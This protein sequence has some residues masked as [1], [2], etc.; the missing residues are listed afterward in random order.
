MTRLRYVVSISFLLLAIP[1]SLTAQTTIP[2]QTL[3]GTV[4][5][6]SSMNPILV[7]GDITIDDNATLN[8]GPG[9]DVRFQ[10]YSDDTHWG[11]DITRSEIIVY[12]TLNVNGTAPGL[13]VLTSTGTKPEGW[14][15]IIF[16]GDS[17]S[18]TIQYANIDHSVFGINFTALDTMLATSATD[19]LIHD[20]GMGMYFDN[21]SSPAVADCTVINAEIA[22]GCWGWDTAPA[23]VNC[24]TSGLTGRA[25]AVY[26]TEGTQPVFTGC[27]FS[28][29]SVDL[30]WSAD[31]VLIDT[32]I[33]DAVNGIIGR[34]FREFAGFKFP[35]DCSLTVN[36][37]N[38]IGT[39]NKGNGIAWDDNLNIL[40]V[41]YSRIGGFLRNVYP[42]WG[43]IDPKAGI[44]HVVGPR[45]VTPCYGTCTGGDDVF[46][47]DS[48]VNFYSI[49]ARIGMTVYN[50]TDGSS[51]T[52]VDVI[53]IPSSPITYNTLQTSGMSSGTNDAGDIYHFLPLASY[54]NIDMGDLGT[55]NPYRYWPP[56]HVPSVGQNE[57]YGAQAPAVPPVVNFELEAGS[58]DPP[59]L[60]QL[61]VWAEGCWWVTDNDAVIDR[62]ILDYEEN[63]NVGKVHYIPHRTPDEKR[64]YSVSGAIEDSLGDPVEGVRVSVDISAQFPGHTVLAATTDAS[65][66]YTIYGLLPSATSYTVVP[67]KLG[68]T[69]TP[70]SR[71]VIIDAANPSD[72]TGQ[73]FVAVLPAPVITSASRA[74]GADGGDYG[75][76][77]RTNWGIEGQTTEIVVTGI[78][79]RETP[80]LFLRG[81]FPGS[82]DTACSNVEFV[83]S[84]KLTAVVSAGME[85]GDYAVKVVNPDG[86]EYVWGDAGT[87]GF[88]IVPPPPPQV[89]N[90]SPNPIN[91]GYSG[92]LSI[93]GRNFVAGCSVGIDGCTWSSLTPENDGT[94][95]I[96]SYQP[97]AISVG[98]WP[99]IVTNPDG[100]TSNDNVTLRVLGAVPTPTPTR[101]PTPPP[102]PTPTPTP[103]PPTP[104]PIP[105]Y[106]RIQPHT[107]AASYLKGDSISLSVEMWPDAGNAFNNLGDLYIAVRPPAGGLLFLS[108]GRWQKSP[109][110]LYR[111]LVIGAHSTVPLG[112][113]KIGRSFPTGAYTL[114]GVLTLP[115][116]SVFNPVQ[117]RSG[118]GSSTF[119]VSTPFL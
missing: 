104:T 63:H 77:G 102:T 85:V 75:L 82:N 49:G 84:T 115:G 48:G 70:P 1:I 37:C 64:T 83:S 50:D 52:V 18:G 74:D 68:Y 34:E 79:F 56:G 41:E 112:S 66:Y 58:Q 25:M 54:N 117:W 8:I 4:N 69:F 73:D 97:L 110:A 67:Q 29:G 109:A 38:V 21:S 65:G 59:S 24:N 39:G 76:P 6:T 100:Q 60:Y 111:K 99:V 32:T 90:V 87:P 28:S 57:F 105:K 31:A 88:T 98:T 16:S 20:V 30:D 118:L 23:I 14:F 11:W 103:I 86:Q 101:T 47:I 27:A 7:T 107:N 71:T 78:N 106:P 113:F 80:S 55:P 91:N 119:T 42:R 93:T 33:A 46:L 19:C 72:V 81:P 13:V 114:Y 96:V 3:Y 108:N 43:S 61:E 92:T 44:V 51:G 40:T 116:G 35:S 15:G 5:W 62:Y 10:E 2:G 89:T 26:A 17:A 12:G 53:S 95:L 22:F 45:F 9:C 36:N 94:S